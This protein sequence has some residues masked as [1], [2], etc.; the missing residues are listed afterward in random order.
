MTKV[1]MCGMM[2]PEDIRAVN[3][4][5]PDYVGF[6]FAE[7]RKRTVSVSEAIRL[8]EDLAGGISAVGVFLDQPLETVLETVKKT[9]MDLI[10][11][12]GSE[13]EEY[14]K[15]VKERSG[16]PVIKAFVLKNPDEIIKSANKSPADYILLDSGAGSGKAFSWELLKEIRRPYFLAGGLNPENAREA[17]ETLHPY[18]LDVSSG[19]ETNGRKDPDK[20][21][22]FA[23]QLRLS[24]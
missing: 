2:R 14:I 22:L 23:E 13:D 10:Q 3:E 19:I 21:K 11:L 24:E 18:A 7:N 16:K 17:L 12:H 4:I 6:I 9:G 15:A 5:R 1:K 20:M 8:R